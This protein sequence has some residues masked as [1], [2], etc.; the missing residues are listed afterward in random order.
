MS[1]FALMDTPVRRYQH[2]DWDSERW[3]GFEPRAGDI[4]ICTCYKSGTTWA[5]M[6]A[7]LL[8]Y[9]T[10]DLPAPLRAFGPGDGWRR[11]MFHGAGVLSL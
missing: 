8:V 3:T 1:E 5:Q 7:A 2:I 10:S 11:T 6:I 4:Y 9:Q